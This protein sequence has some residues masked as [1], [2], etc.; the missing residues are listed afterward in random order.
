MI[1]L[2]GCKASLLALLL[3]RTSLTEMEQSAKAQQDQ[4]LHLQSK[5]SVRVARLTEAGQI[6]ARLHSLTQLVNVR[7]MLPAHV[8]METKWSSPLV[9][10]VVR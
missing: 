6:A 1:M 4:A 7:W 10:S 5:S 2:S 3:Q 8:E 9:L